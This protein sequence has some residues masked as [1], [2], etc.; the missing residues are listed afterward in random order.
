MFWNRFAYLVD[1]K[2]SGNKK[3]FSELTHIPYTS[4]VEYYK[5][6]KTDPQI[7]LINKIV[8][9]FEDV[10][11]NWL[12]N[13]EEEETNFLELEFKETS[14]KQALKKKMANDIQKEDKTTRSTPQKIK[15]HKEYTP[16]PIE[17]SILNEPN[18]EYQTQQKEITS[19]KEQLKEKDER[20]QDLKSQI[21]FLQSL[22]TK[23]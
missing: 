11:V 10:D 5:G 9:T 16:K 2:C 3:K 1:Y 20:I 18:V 4:V 14:F 21:E 7:S 6:K 22:L 17:Q 23:Q 19:L 8:N 12:V 13:D 15:D